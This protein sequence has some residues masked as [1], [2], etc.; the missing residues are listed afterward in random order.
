MSPCTG[1]EVLRSLGTGALGEVTFAA[2]EEHVEGCPLCTAFIERLAVRPAVMPRSPQAD[3]GRLPCIP[4]FEIRS[5]LGRGSMGVVYLAIEKR[6]NR[7]VAL[8]VLQRA[9]GSNAS[10]GT[11]RRWLRET[12]AVSIGRHPNVVSLYNYGEI[13]D[14][15]FLVLEYVPGGTLKD[16]LTEP[17]PCA[18]LLP[19]W[20]RRSSP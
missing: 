9:V 11:R 15:F 20:L 14:C 8:K 3:A 19:A 18:V 4:E 16:R 17:L 10:S 13:D 7:L 5:E 6:L 12:R 1:E 2:I